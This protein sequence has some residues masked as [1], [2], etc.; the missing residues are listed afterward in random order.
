[1]LTLILGGARSGKSR[2][3]QAM[4]E[5][6]E[7]VVYVATARADDDEEMRARVARHRADRPASWR[8][9]EEPLDVERAVATA[10][11][12]GATVLV[13]CVTVWLANLAW[14]HRD[15]A[16]EEVERVALE[17]TAELARVSHARRAILVSN[18]VGWGI[19]PEHPVGRS[20]RDL[21]G[22]ANQL[23]AREAER[24]VLMVAGLPLVLKDGGE[25][26]SSLDAE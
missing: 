14:A 13:D 18:E 12:A 20:F 7:S 21:Q 22:L 3:A 17:R 2:Y 5:T 25:R 4:C 16:P 26:Q 1:M 10:T 11:P 23:L 19:V 24:V 15:A 8:T 6:A 9:V